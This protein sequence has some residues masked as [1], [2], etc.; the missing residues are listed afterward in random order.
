MAASVLRQLQFAVAAWRED[1]RTDA[2]LLGR[3]IQD[4][5]E[6]AF[7]TLVGRHGG[8]VWGV[9]VRRLGNTPDAEDAFQATFLRLARG[10]RSVR[11]A[12]LLPNWLY[13]AARCCVA[14]VRR[15]VDRQNRIRHR[16]AR[17]VTLRGKPERTTD[18]AAYLEHELAC[19]A[20]ED[21]AL[22]LMCVVEQRTY[23]E[24][25]GELG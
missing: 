18:L 11:E 12:G 20:A 25:A 22:L 24:V 8:L 6:R 10:A 14:D 13:R 3:F 17:E 16:L 2:E 1:G 4:R 7:G 19:L 9:C 15:A 23:A 5:D 21:R